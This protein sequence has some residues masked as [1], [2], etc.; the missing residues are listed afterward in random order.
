MTVGLDPGDGAVE[1]ILLA[2]VGLGEAGRHPREL[3]GD[4]IGLPSQGEQALATLG[5]K[6]STP[7]P[8]AHEK[9][10]TKHLFG[11]KH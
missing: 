1:A 10:Y 3:E 8:H 11:I 9:K 4:A 7:T 6:H 2:L 5:S